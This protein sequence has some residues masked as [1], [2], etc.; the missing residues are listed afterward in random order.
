[1]SRD[2]WELHTSKLQAATPTWINFL[3]V[4]ASEPPAAT[5]P[6]NKD[7]KK[8]VVRSG[9]GEVTTDDAEVIEAGC[10]CHREAKG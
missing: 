5:T 10:D 1:M 7:L 6:S 4:G 2:L 8:S 9:N 3:D